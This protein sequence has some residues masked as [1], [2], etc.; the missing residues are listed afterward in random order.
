MEKRCGT[1]KHWKKLVTNPLS[2]GLCE[3]KITQP[4]PWWLNFID[5]GLLGPFQG[6]GCEAW[7]QAER[8]I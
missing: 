6:Y 3:W 4:R 8:N 2:W 7:V 5:Y 1:C